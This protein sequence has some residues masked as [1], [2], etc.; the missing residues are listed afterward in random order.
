M[1]LS[2]LSAM[3][4]LC[5]AAAAQAQAPSPAPAVTIYGLLDAGVE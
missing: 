2:H 5:G 3:T 4:I 1:K